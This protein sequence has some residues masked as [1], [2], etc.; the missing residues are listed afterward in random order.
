MP[1]H[2]DI[3]TATHSILKEREAIQREIQSGKTSLTDLQKRFGLGRSSMA[4]IL[5]A[6]SIPHRKESITFSLSDL[7][8]EVELARADAKTALDLIQELRRE[9]GYAAPKVAA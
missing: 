2:Q 7:K 4:S 8:R 1:S 3:A 6:L 5:D 9:L